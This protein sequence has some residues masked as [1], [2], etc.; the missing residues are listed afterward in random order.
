MNC[1]HLTL[2]S[3]NRKTGCM[4]VSTSPSATCPASCPFK[5]KGCYAQGGPIAIH[6]AKVSSGQ[7]GTV[8]SDFTSQISQLP[9]NTIWR[10]NQ[11]GDL[12]GSKNRINKTALNE[13][14]AANKGK[15]G[16]TYTHYSPLGNTRYAKL[17]RQAIKAANKNG[18]TINVSAESLEQ[19]DRILDLNIGPV[20]LTVASNAQNTTTKKGRKVVICPAQKSNTTCGQCKLCAKSD[21]KVI[22]GFRSHGFRSK[23]VDGLVS[24]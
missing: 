16:Y 13:L 22:V 15:L 14:V 7:R 9:A 1:Y 17:N 5:G 20:V 18:F 10:H 23:Q 21:R 19:A 4:P 8:W 3:G 6:W 2:K 11:S 24:E 12:R